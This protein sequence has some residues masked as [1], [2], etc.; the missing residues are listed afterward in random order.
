MT[1]NTTTKARGRGKR[2]V[3]VPGG[4]LLA[5]VVIAAIVY[6][7]GLYRL[8]QLG[9]QVDQISQD[10]TRAG[11][12]WPRPSGTC[13]GCHGYGGNAGSQVYPHLAGQP[14]PYLKKQLVAFVSGERSDPNM[15]PM[16]L[17]MSQRELDGLVAYFSK[18]A[19]LPNTTFHADAARV[20]R[21]EALV[22]ASNCAVCHGQKLEGKDVYPR[23][24][25]QGH[26]YL[27]DQLTRFK[28]G[29]RRDAT[30]AMPAVAGALSQR[31]IEDL[32]QYIASR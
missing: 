31:D 15:T 26:D 4:L 20:A 9:K 18:M 5:V 16:A 29:A 14:E 27:V 8:L 10:D 17:S 6:G 2:M 1:T 21:G 7:P 32:A 22:K 23:L 11:G 3:I 30:G 12:P 13:I 24:A 28:S 19:P 25:G